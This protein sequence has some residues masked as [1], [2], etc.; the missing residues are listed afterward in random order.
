MNYLS[1]ENVSKRYGERLLFEHVTFGI[2][3]GQKVALVAKRTG[4]STLFRVIMG[5]ESPDTG[6]VAFNKGIRVSFLAQEHGLEESW[7]ILDNLRRRR[8]CAYRHPRVRRSPV[9]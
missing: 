3:K 5:D 4:K 9:G 8:P 2:L 7:N 1:V 6:S